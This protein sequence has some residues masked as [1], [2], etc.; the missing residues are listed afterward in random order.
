MVYYRGNLEHDIENSESAS[1][2]R[3]ILIHLRNTAALLS[4]SGKVRLEPGSLAL[5]LVASWRQGATGR[6]F[7]QLHGVLAHALV[8]FPRPP[9]CLSGVDQFDD[10]CDFDR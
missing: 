5:V 2:Y 8:Y 10:A 6:S 1:A 3:E 9:R 7:E 4:K